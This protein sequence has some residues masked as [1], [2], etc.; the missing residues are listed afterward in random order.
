[1]SF[2]PEIQQIE[3]RISIL[4]SAMRSEVL[5]YSET[6]GAG[7]E[8]RFPIYKLSFGSTDPQ[9]PVLGF[10]GGVHGLERIGAQVSV[11][12]LNSFSELVLWDKNL[13]RTLQDIRVFFIPTVNPIGIYRKTRSNPRG[14]D[15][16]RN[17]PVDADDPPRFLGGHRYTNKLPWYRG[18]FGAPME[19]EAQAM[20]RGVQ[21]E[22]RES[23]LAIT[24]DSHSGFGLQDRLWFPYAKTLKPF[25]DLGLLYSF[26]QLLD[27]TYPHHFYRIEPQAGTYT[28]HGDLWDYIYDH[29]QSPEMGQHKNYLPLCLE[30]G[31]WMWLK[32]NPWQI[33]KPEGP[34]NPLIGHRHKRTLRRHNTLMEFLIRAVSSPDEWAELNAAKT[35]E[36]ESKAMELWYAK[37]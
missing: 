10:V 5:A 4:G 31:S 8:L 23:K 26:K 21:D 18:E 25:P 7:G 19:V 27:R 1:M 32:K 12:L 13:Q 24:V 15:L 3:Q 33:F 28:T 11:A 30:M 37:S 35:L 9:A 2:L 22:I 20:I 36:L 6:S 16:M 14:I 17:A 29:H 34:F